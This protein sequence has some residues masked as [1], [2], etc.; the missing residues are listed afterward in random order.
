MSNIKTALEQ[1]K[2]LVSEMI[3][4]GC[5]D[6]LFDVITHIDNHLEIERQQK[7]E[8]AKMHVEAALYKISKSTYD[9]KSDQDEYLIDMIE[10]YPLENIK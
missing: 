6:S 8:F 3:Y 1:V 7:I 4:F 10:L 5:D 9:S 2:E